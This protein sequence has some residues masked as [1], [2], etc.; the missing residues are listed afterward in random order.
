LDRRAQGVPTV[1]TPAANSGPLPPHLRTP[2]RNGYSLKLTTSG[3]PTRFSRGPLV[4]QVLTHARTYFPS[5]YN[6]HK[7]IEHAGTRLRLT[8]WS[9][10]GQQCS[11]ATLMDPSEPPRGAGWDGGRGSAYLGGGL[12]QEGVEGG[13]GA[14]GAQ[15]GVVLLPRQQRRSPLVL[16]RQRLPA[17]GALNAR[18]ALGPAR[19]G[20]NSTD[21]GQK[22]EAATRGEEEGGRQSQGAPGKTDHCR[23]WSP[24]TL[25][26]SEEGL[27]AAEM[28][29]AGHAFASNRG[30]TAAA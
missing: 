19:T 27:A 26:A 5:A 25:Q 17:H 15:R 23:H 14:A 18:A 2:T 6:L 12:V 29:R 30:R 10:Q 13:G 22:Q 9:C 24:R 20:R 11:M 21:K 16:Q 3:K 8:P 28:G 7:L 1:A 4:R